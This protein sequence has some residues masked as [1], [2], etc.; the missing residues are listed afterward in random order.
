MAFDTF[1]LFLKIVFPWSTLFHM[2]TDAAIKRLQPRA[3]PY[4]EFEGG[5][6]PG[7][8]VQVTPTG[9]RTFY[10]QHTAHGHRRFYRL[11]QYPHLSLSAARAVARDYLATLATGGDP[12]APK[13][14]GLGTVAD[15]LD[16]WLVHQRERDGRRLDDVERAIRG[17]CAAVMERAAADIT[18]SDIRDILAKIHQRG[19]RVMANRVRAHLHAMWVYGMRHDHDPRQLH[20]PVRFGLESNPVIAVPRD[21]AAERVGERALT[22]AEVREV[23]TTDRLSVPARQACRILLYS[24]AR[25]NE[26]VQA[27]WSEFDMDARLWT[28]PA[29][30]AKTRR[31]LLTPLTPLAVEL[32]G[33]LRDIFGDTAWLFPCRNVHWASQPWGATALGHAVRNAGYDWTARDLRRTWKTLAGGA[34]LGLEIRN[35]IQGHALQDVGSRHYD[36]HS[37]LEE[38]RTALDQWEHCLRM[39]LAGDNVMSIRRA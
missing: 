32:L 15:L 10:L 36:R 29:E 11:G 27:P 37:Y 34:G 38:K 4:R 39:K 7:F 31:H 24:G 2:F 3:A 9:T 25:V 21:S 14:A 22:W 6:I 8:C 33:E 23:W 19:S 35:R 18:A 26:V 28:L 16:A 30:R 5:E 13:R 12:Q 1:Q 17:N 20:R